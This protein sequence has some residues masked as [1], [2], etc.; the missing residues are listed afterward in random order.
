MSWYHLTM[1]YWTVDG[2]RA[3]VMAASE[4]GL[5]RR[6]CWRICRLERRRDA[7]DGEADASGYHRAT[8]RECRNSIGVRLAWLIEGL[9]RI[10]FSLAQLWLRRSKH[11]VLA[12]DGWRPHARASLDQG[13]QHLVEVR[14]RGA[15]VHGARGSEAPEF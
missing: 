2:E 10:D 6:V 7:Q 3:V 14:D 11:C 15:L 8:S 4:R 5:H 13:R 9:D 1:S 12:R